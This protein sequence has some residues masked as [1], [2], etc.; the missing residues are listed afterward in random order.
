MANWALE[1]FTRFGDYVED[2][3]RSMMLSI[4]GIRRVESIVPL[5]E[6]VHNRNILDMTSEEARESEKRLD[7]TR[8]MAD[9]ARREIDRGFPFIHSYTLVGTWGAFE[10]AVEDLAVTVLLNDPSTRSAESLSKIRGNLLEFESMDIEDRTRFVVYEL[11]R[12]LKAEDRLGVNVFEGVLSAIGLGG[13]VDGST[14][15]L[16]LE[17]QQLRHVIVHRGSVADKQLVERCPWLGLKI[18]QKIL[19][20]HD[21]FHRLTKAMA[22]YLG[23]ILDRV[24]KKFPS[25]K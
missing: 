9:F 6:A 17:Y 15:K 22:D 14:R 25:E 8:K 16:M 11:Q 19:L 13:S 21:D 1:P 12:N 7:D 2:A 4:N 3:H 5:S 20:N 23:S 10:A 18:G 24:R